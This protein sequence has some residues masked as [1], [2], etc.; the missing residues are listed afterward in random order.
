MKTTLL[1]LYA[2]GFVLTFIV[3][4]YFTILNSRQPWTSSL[5]VTLLYATFWP[6]YLLI[7]LA[8]FL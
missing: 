7:R 4:G 2:V 6:V 8:S 3:V 5:G 1:I